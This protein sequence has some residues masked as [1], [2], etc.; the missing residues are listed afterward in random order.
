[1]T[2]LER[3]QD[4][5]VISARKVHRRYHTYF[6]QADVVQELMIWVLRRTDKVQEW[7]DHEPDAPEYKIGEK[8]LG[9]TLVRHA[10]KY[11]RKIKAQKLGY[12][13][14]DEQFYAPATLAELLPFVWTDVVG[15]QDTSKPRVSGGGNPAEGGNYVVQLIDIRRG[16]LA[17]SEADRQVL[18][19]KYYDQ[20]S[21]KELAQELQVSD[22]TAHRKV[23]GAIKRLENNLGGPNPYERKSNADV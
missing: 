3:A 10:D 21:F 20:L 8:M 15:T 2:W 22:T 4:I 17:L 9:K 1:M 5:A 12:E 19:L 11:C 13:L 18:R 23:D 14:R 7:L 16:L 6:D